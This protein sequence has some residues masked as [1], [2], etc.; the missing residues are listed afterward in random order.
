MDALNALNCILKKVDEVVNFMLCMF[1]HSEK[2][3]NVE[4]KSLK[5][6]EE[7]RTQPEELEHFKNRRTEDIPRRERE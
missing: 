3:E 7:T 4:G 5:G 1:Y 6:K 2:R